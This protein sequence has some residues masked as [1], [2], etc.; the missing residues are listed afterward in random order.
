MHILL[1]G[2]VE[3]MKKM[4]KNSYLMK[5]CK[6]ATWLHRSLVE[7]ETTSVLFKEQKQKKKKRKKKKN[8]KWVSGCQ[9]T[10][11]QRARP[12]SI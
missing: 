8:Q 12:F 7:I 3:M 1:H 6:I 9:G 2:Q 5:E 10:R 11:T 4:E